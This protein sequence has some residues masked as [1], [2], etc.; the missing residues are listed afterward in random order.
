VKRRFFRGTNSP[1]TG[2]NDYTPFHDVDASGS[3]LASDFSEV[4]KRFFD[5]LPPVN[6]TAST[7]GNRRARPVGRT[8]LGIGPA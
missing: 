6:V 3:I 4:K 7:F 8:V 2:S 1:V 5:T